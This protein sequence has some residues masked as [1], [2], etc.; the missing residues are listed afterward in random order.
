MDNARLKIRKRA[1]V[2]LL[3][4]FLRWFSLIPVG[5]GD[6]SLNVLSADFSSFVVIGGKSSFSRLRFAL[7]WGLKITVYCVDVVSYSVSEV[8]V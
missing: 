2:I 5:P 6:L 3:G 1:V 4:R 7:W 8:V